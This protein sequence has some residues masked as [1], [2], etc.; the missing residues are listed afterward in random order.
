MNNKELI[1]RIDKI[2]YGFLPHIQLLQDC[3]K[4]LQDAEADAK[5]QAAIHLHEEAKLLEEINRLKAWNEAIKTNLLATI[6]EADL[7]QAKLY[8]QVDP[9]ELVIW[10]FEQYNPMIKPLPE[11]AKAILEQFKKERIK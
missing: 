1:E 5:K 10:L 3:K 9:I 6:E 8:E 4:S 11:R 2:K 7:F